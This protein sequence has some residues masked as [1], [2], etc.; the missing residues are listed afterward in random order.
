MK[1]RSILISGAGIAGPTLAYWLHRYGFDVTVVEGAAAPR[2]GGHAVDIRGTAREVAA[3]TGI[4]PAVRAAHTGARGM[5]F[6]DERG[7]RVASFD[8]AVF[9]DSG[10]PVA[11]LAIKRTDLAR[12]LYEA[13]LNDVEYVF[14][15]S[16]IAAQQDHDGVHVQFAHGEPRHVDLL[17]GADGVHSAVRRLMFGP[18]EEYVRDLG[19]YLSMY[20][21]TTDVDLDGWQLMYTMP[22]GAGGPGRT[23]GLYPQ[24]TPGTALAGFFLPSPP[25]DHDRRDVDEQKRTVLRAFAGQGWEIPRMLD[26]I[27]DAPDFYFDRVVQVEVDGWSRG[28]T[29]LLGDAGYCASP[30]SGI[31][32]S[33][34]L[35]GAYVL[36]GE[37]AAADGDHTRAFRAYEDEM[38][39]FTARAHAFARAS[40]DGGLMPR[41]RGQIRR[42]NLSVRLLPYLPQALVGRGMDR[43]ARTVTLKDYPTPVHR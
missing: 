35:V 8:P 16:V 25:L 7:T 36:A 2:T 23:A 14:D 26:S 37:L 32:T 6:V 19:L 3:R 34:A 38:R 20:S 30:M 31:G 5:A 27:W 9:G 11:E 15:D 4:V 17:V 39:E 43:V 12:I 42:R 18:H 29:V 28:R 13:T 1:N 22:G 41:T 40:G 21:I 33:L 24:R 10:G